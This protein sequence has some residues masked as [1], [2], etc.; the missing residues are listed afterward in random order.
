VISCR[1][2]HFNLLFVFEALSFLWGG[3]VLRQTLSVVSGL[4]CVPMTLVS[5]Y[6]L[7]MKMPATGQGG[8]RD[9]GKPLPRRC[10]PPMVS[11]TARVDVWAKARAFR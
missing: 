5:A 10:A 3:R 7:P 4:E 11:Q 6:D 1:R 2:P 8:G 9:R